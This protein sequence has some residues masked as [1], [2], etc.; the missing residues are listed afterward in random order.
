MEWKKICPCA[1]AIE[2]YELG[3]QHGLPPVDKSRE[4]PNLSASLFSQRGDDPLQYYVFNIVLDV[5]QVSM[6]ELFMKEDNNESEIVWNFDPVVEC[7]LEDLNAHINIGK[8]GK[9]PAGDYH[10]CVFSVFSEPESNIF[11]LFLLRKPQNGQ[12]SDKPDVMRF[13]A[14]TNGL[15]IEAETLVIL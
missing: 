3:K 11:Y 1:E 12:Y 2:K 8:Q 7:M 14:N 6:F 13:Y 9:L 15:S 5:L 4:M 10:N